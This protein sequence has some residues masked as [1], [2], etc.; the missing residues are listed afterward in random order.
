MRI[1][2]FIK[3]ESIAALNLSL[4]VAVLMAP[5]TVLRADE[6][7]ESQQD[8]ALQPAETEAHPHHIKIRKLADYIQ[9]KY[10]VSESKAATIVTEAF[11]NAIRYKSLE[12]ELILAIIA[13]ESTFKERAVSYQ[14]SRGLMQVLPQA[15]P[16]KVQ[17]IGGVHA[18]FDP[19]KNIY[20]GTKIL[21][22]YLQDSDG[23]LKRALLRYNGGEGNTN[24]R[25]AE[26]VLRIYWDM[27]RQTILG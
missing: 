14:G 25:Y 10:R 26:K 4:I 20:T 2:R 12:P 1:V 27:R 13:V 22:S 5:L 24:W 3:H 8:V 19:E 18:L 15:H 9:K 6:Y 17:A 16:S 11:R 7:Q 21:A 23:N